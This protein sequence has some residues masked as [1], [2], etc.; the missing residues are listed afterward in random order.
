MISCLQLTTKEGDTNYSTNLTYKNT[1]FIVLSDSAG[2]VLTEDQ[3]EEAIS[4]AKEQNHPV[5]LKYPL[6]ENNISRYFFDIVFRS[7]F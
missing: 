1:R 3:L 2:L 7:S 5:L 6:N 4:K